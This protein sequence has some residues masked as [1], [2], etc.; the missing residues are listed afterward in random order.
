ADP[1][2]V[3]RVARGEDPGVWAGPLLVQREGWSLRSLPGRRPREDRDA[4]PPRRVRAVR[5]VQRQTVQSRDARGAFPRTVD[6]RSAGADGGRR[7]GVLPEPAAHLAE[8]ADARRRRPW[9][10][11][12]WPE[13]DDA[14]GRWSAAR[15]GRGR[16]HPETREM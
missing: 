7:A 5:G 1:R 14:L 9:L 10:H 2:A 11:P 12:P 4:L 8:A 3:R 6:L 13:R 15:E 16:A